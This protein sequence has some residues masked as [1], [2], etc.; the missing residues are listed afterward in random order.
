MIARAVYNTSMELQE[1]L[2][3]V[4]Q[5]T[6][7]PANSPAHRLM[8]DM[9]ERARQI[10]SRMNQGYQTQEQLQALFAELTDQPIDPTFHLFPPFYSDFGRNIRVG[11]DVFINEGCCFQD[12]GGIEIGDGSLIGHQVVLVTL[13]H[14]LEPSR[15][16]DMIPSKIVIGRGVWI[17]AHATVLAGVTIGDHAVVAAGAVVTRDVPPNTVVAGVPARIIKTIKE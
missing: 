8:H 5:G 1:Y 14:A 16:A 9:A 3:W 2:S 12:Q 7:I 10:T 6:T 17:G 13:N 11:K 4:N 15:R